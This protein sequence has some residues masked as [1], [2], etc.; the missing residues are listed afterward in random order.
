MTNS[1]PPE[2]LARRNKERR[3][4]AER[5][6]KASD[7]ANK[8]AGTTSGI[9]LAIAGAV[10]T[11]SSSALG[12]NNFPIQGHRD[13]KIAIIWAWALIGVAAMVCL[14]D[15]A[16]DYR[17]F[18]KRLD[19]EYGI[20][21]S[22]SMEVSPEEAKDQWASKKPG[23]STGLWLL[24]IEAALIFVGLTLLFTVFAKALLQSQ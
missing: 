18:K 12:S 24:G 23:N 4:R 6:D 14:I 16:R 2:E 22:I 1:L 13:W 7:E 19:Y 20:A 9:L 17:F 21:E 15:L 8:I 3:A 5:A 11:F 10:L